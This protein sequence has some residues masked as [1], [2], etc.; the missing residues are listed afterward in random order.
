VRFLFL[1]LYPIKN[2]ILHISLS[3]HIMQ[4]HM[5]TKRVQTILFHIQFLWMIKMIIFQILFYLAS[6]IP[7]SYVWTKIPYFHI[8]IHIRPNLHFIIILY[9]TLIIH[10]RQCSASATSSTC[11]SSLKVVKPNPI[12]VCV[13]CI[14][15]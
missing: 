11:A 3:L 10:C 12:Q 6:P 15:W 4:V 5:Q 13:L 1:C 9:P 8:L 14:V 2:T 7:S